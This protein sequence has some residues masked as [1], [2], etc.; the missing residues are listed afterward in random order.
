MGANAE[1]HCQ[2][3]GRAQR[4]QGRVE[5]T[6]IEARGVEDTRR[7]QPTERAKQ[8]SEGLIETEVATTQPTG[9][10]LGPLHI[11]CVCLAWGFV[12][13]LTVGVG[14]SLTLLPVLRPFSSY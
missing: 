10:A 7:T 2:I 14:M 12:T 1:T 3:F 8:G 4:T 11:R 6:I 9:S 13:L 5:G